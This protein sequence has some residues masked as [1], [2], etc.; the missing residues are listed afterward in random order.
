[1]WWTTL[2]QALVTAKS[3]GRRLQDWDPLELRDHLAQNGG[4][5]LDTK[6]YVGLYGIYLLGDDERVVFPPRWIFEP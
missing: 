6:A 3:Q 4:P 1:M 2:G 5:S